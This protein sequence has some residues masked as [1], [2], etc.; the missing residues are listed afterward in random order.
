MY[1]FCSV[2][3]LLLSYY[4]PQGATE[5]NLSVVSGDWNLD[6]T[7][8]RFISGHSW[9]CNTFD[10]LNYSSRNQSAVLLYVYPVQYKSPEQRHWIAHQLPTAHNT[11][12]PYVSLF[13]YEQQQRL[14][15]STI[16]HTLLLNTTSH[17]GW[18]IRRMCCLRSTGCCMLAILY[19][20]VG[21]CF[22]LLSTFLRVVFLNIYTITFAFDILYQWLR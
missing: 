9:I 14:E 13:W 18:Q 20:N 4:T 5:N 21:K 8:T 7:H 16:R 2:A 15:E 6:H 11:R 3:Q 17:A 12:L 22:I 19:G 1:Y 10:F